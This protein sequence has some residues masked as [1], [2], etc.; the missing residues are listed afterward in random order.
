MTLEAR[1]GK[2][3]GYRMAKPVIEHC[4]IISGFGGGVNEI[5]AMVD[6]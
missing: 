6:W 3:V 1:D 2:A 5:F 4:D